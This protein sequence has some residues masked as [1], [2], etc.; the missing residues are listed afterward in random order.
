MVLIPAVIRP[1][2]I[3]V[4][5][6]R[7]ASRLGWEGPFFWGVGAGAVVGSEG[8]SGAL[9]QSQPSTHSSLMTV[10]DLTVGDSEALDEALDEVL[11]GRFAW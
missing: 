11:S 1:L 5:P 9:P 7:M 10:G 2:R 3:G 6:W 4:T 8:V